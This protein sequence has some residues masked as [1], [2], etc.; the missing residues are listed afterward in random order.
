MEQYEEY[1]LGLDVAAVVS[2]LVIFLFGNLGAESVFMLA[3]ELIFALG[4]LALAFTFLYFMQLGDSN[5]LLVPALV[6]LGIGAALTFFSWF[7]GGFAKVYN[8]L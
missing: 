3:T 2:A 8:G 7:V 5:W 6:V 1:I 4:V